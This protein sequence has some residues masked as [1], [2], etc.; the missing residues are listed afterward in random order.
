MDWFAKYMAC[1]DCFR[2]I[3]T[4][5]V[6]EGS[7]SVLFEG[8]QKKYDTRLISALKAERMMRSGCEGYIAFIYEKKPIQELRDIPIVCEF[9]DVFPNEVLGLPAR[10]IFKKGSRLY[11]RTCARYCTDIQ[12][13]VQN[14]TIRVV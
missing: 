6:D 10:S 1:L 8:A 7:A 12:G 5:R 4:F 11:Y 3:I 9:P 2:K 13:T 14:D